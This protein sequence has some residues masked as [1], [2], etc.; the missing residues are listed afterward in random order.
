MTEVEVVRGQLVSSTPADQEAEVEAWIAEAESAMVDDPEVIERAIVGRILTAD[1]VD[2]ILGTAEVTGA[3]DMVG[4]PFTLTGVRWNPS[5]IATGL[6]FYA[7]LEGRLLGNG[8]GVAISCSAKSVMAQ[9][10]QLSRKGL[11]PVDVV[12][13]QAAKPTAAG[14]YPLHLEA[15]PP[16]T[17][18]GAGEAF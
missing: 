14:F 5:G 11:L 17:V 10:H 12:I 8:D 7:L 3:A 16:A 2:A 1:T 18:D 6:R 4:V 13:R 9:A 15:A